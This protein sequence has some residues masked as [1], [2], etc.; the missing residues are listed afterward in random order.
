M[1]LLITG[2]S[3]FIGSRLIPNLIAKGHSVT[4]L[5]LLPPASSS[6]LEKKSFK[7]VNFDLTSKADFPIDISAYDAVIPMAAIVGREQCDVS[8]VRTVAINQ[9]SIKK[10][11]SRLTENQLLIYP[12]TNMGFSTPTDSE[13][14]EF[15][16]NSELI[17]NSLYT[18]TKCIAEEEIFLHPRSVSLRL[19][20]MFGHSPAMKDHLLMHYLI[21]TAVIEQ[22]LSIFEPMVRRSFMHI[23]DLTNLIDEILNQPSAAIGQKINAFDERLNLTKVELVAVLAEHIDFQIEIIEGRDPDGRNYMIKSTYLEKIGFECTT[24]LETSIVELRNY[25]GSYRN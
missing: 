1:D 8:P 16:D 4:S 20:S 23:D 11:V 24:S 21:K 3:G 2:G 13:T 12:Q 7:F 25:Y 19:S 18:E 22:K 17:P 14:R 10:L 15:D 5:D 6:G 9:E